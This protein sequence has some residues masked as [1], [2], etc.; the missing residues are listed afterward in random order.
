MEFL[1]SIFYYFTYPEII[2]TVGNWI[3]NHLGF[4][5]IFT[6]VLFILILFL[7]QA[8]D[9]KNSQTLKKTHVFHSFL[10]VHLDCTECLQ[11]QN[12]CLLYEV[13]LLIPLHFQAVLLLRTGKCYSWNFSV[14]ESVW[15]L[16]APVWLMT[17][18]SNLCS[19]CHSSFL[20][21]SVCHSV[22][23]EAFIAA[24]YPNGSLFCARG[25][26]KPLL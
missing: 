22:H 7:L 26:Q 14:K 15:S 8:F 25:E 18:G 9:Q 10:E 12:H 1:C 19:E 23:E 11:G 4:S 16:R 2:S 5:A 6:A 20:S 24:V 17:E 3:K 13:V 21:V